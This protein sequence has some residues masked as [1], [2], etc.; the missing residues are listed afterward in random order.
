MCQLKRDQRQKSP[1]AC[2]AAMQV[3]VPAALSWWA[4]AW[5]G[6]VKQDRRK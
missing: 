6:R 4:P 5:P 3:V 2:A 1:V